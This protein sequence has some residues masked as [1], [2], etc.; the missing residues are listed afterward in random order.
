MVTRTTSEE[1]TVRIWASA[2][3]AHDSGTG[4]AALVLLTPFALAL[5][6]YL[7]AVAITRRRGRPWP[8]YRS[9]FWMLGVG[10]AASAFGGPTT[11]GGFAAHMMG[12]LLAGMVSPLLLVLAAPA[13]LALRTLGVVPARRLSRMLNSAP[14]RI[15]TH[16][17]VAAVISVGSLWVLYRT[18]LFALMLTDPLVH[19]IVMAHVLIAGYLFTVSLV[20]VDPAPHR[21]SFRVRAAVLVLA[22][23]AHG[24]LAKSLAAV[25]PA[26]VTAAD[27]EAGARL[28][29]SGGDAVELVIAVLLCARAYQAAGRRFGA[30]P[31]RA[32]APTARIHGRG[33]TGPAKE[34]KT[35]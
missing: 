19:V 31:G 33:V 32:L 13:T 9:V 4:I 34:W 3:H 25:P 7:S 14:A 10:A 16:P 18:S 2:M 6:M 29:F 28:M 22:I 24:I 5:L 26:G 20:S 27:A 21:A 11:H 23:A 15:L 12:H 1:G 8:W 30:A 17:A 35:S